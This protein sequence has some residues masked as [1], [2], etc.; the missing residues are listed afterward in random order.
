M[1]LCH[2]DDSGSVIVAEA[3]QTPYLMDA[4]HAETIAVMAGIDA[5]AK[6]GIVQVKLGTDSMMLMYAMRGQ[7]TVWLQQE[8]FSTK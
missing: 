8:V 2:R 6:K 4:F 1:G 3:G 5:A 7:N